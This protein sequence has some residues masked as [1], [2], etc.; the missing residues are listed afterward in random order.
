MSQQ[1][2][3]LILEYEREGD[4]LRKYGHGGIG[5]VTVF[6]VELDGS[7]VF[8]EETEEYRPD[9]LPDGLV[10]VE[11]CDE[12]LYCIDCSSGKVVSWSPYDGDGVVEVYE[13]FDSHLLGRFN[14]AIE[15]M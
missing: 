3:A 9:G 11:N 1:V 14:D 5:G 15:N 10:V 4:F 8:A 12:R 6:G 13:D 2:E 7:M